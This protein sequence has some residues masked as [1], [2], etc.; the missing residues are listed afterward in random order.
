[1][2]TANLPEFRQEGQLRVAGLSNSITDATTLT[3]EMGVPYLWVDAMCIIQEADGRA[4]KA[5]QIPVMDAVYGLAELT[6]VQA[7]GQNSKCHLMGFGDNSTPPK[8]IQGEI[9]PGLRVA[10]QMTGFDDKQKPGDTPQPVKS[11]SLMPQFG[12]Q[13]LPVEASELQEIYNKLQSLESIDHLG[14][15]DHISR[16]ES[17]VQE[18]TSR[19]MTYWGDKL[20]AF[21]GL[22]AIYERQ[23]DTKL[24]FGLPTN[25]LDMAL[26]WSTT[27]GPSLERL[28]DFPSWSWTGWKGAVHYSTSNP[29]ALSPTCRFWI[30]DRDLRAT[31]DGM[32][33]SKRLVQTWEA[34]DYVPH[35]RQVRVRLIDPGNR[36]L[37]PKVGVSGSLDRSHTHHL[38]PKMAFSKC[39]GFETVH[40]QRLSDFSNKDGRKL[41]LNLTGKVVGGI[42]LDEPLGAAALTADMEPARLN[43]CTSGQL[44]RGEEYWADANC[45]DK[46]FPEFLFST[47]GLGG[48]KMIEAKTSLARTSESHMKWCRVLLVE[49]RADGSMKRKGVGDM[50]AAALYDV[51]Q[52]MCFLSCFL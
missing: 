27:D 48:N 38:D 20:N 1:M 22:G 7:S 3:E 33:L 5:R 35:E 11:S 41:V 42:A 2:T 16:Y 6:I 51:E 28:P 12:S 9:M 17:T 15:N 52:K 34:D 14:R 29:E 45:S 23:M 19:E 13:M 32:I 30:V 43:L 24:V 40:S 49:K 25:Q 8:Q 46:Y 37:Y 47:P 4:D 18:Y 10:V 50:V 31:G 21:A 44:D 26:L 36:T 39:L